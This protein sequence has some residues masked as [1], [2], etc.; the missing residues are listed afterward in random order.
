M[1]ITKSQLLIAIAL[2]AALFAWPAQAGDKGSGRGGA[3][4]L[5]QPMQNDECR[6][7]RRPITC[8]MCKDADWSGKAASAN[9]GN[10]SDCV[11]EK[12]ICPKCGMDRSLCGTVLKAASANLHAKDSVTRSVP[13]LKGD[14][15]AGSHEH[16]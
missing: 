7:T 11:T 2:A 9:R 4:D 5:I 15:K 3:G 8:P 14:K 1:R 16:N 12:N 6:E 10:K 13:N